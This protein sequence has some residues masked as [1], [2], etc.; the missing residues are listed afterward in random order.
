MVRNAAK[1]SA[2]G[3]VIGAAMLIPG[4]SGSTAAI[5]LGIYDRLLS[6]VG[7]I[8][9]QPKRSLPFLAAAG[10]GAAVGA[11]L[12]SGLVLTLYEGYTWLTMSFFIGAVLGSIPALVK[13]S[14]IK[15]SG[16]L[17]GALF[18]PLGAAAALSVGLIPPAAFSMG[19]LSQMIC[20][21]VIAVAL[22][23]PGISTSQLLL[24]LGMYESFWRAVHEVRVSELFFLAAGG[25]VGTFLTAKAAD[26]MFRRHR[27]E[28]YMLLTGFV[29]ASVREMIP[30]CPFDSSP[31]LC[32]ISFAA[33]FLTVLVVMMRVR[34]EQN[35]A[36]KK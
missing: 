8:F 5:I 18:L 10:C 16:N 3:A 4:V 21:F 29:A 26:C 6:A 23:L 34:P 31:L 15:E 7:S 35:E 14:E 11:G 33:G 1:T 32:G 24:T 30:D 13:A 25:A 2:A 20:G 36:H 27:F 9:S 19:I 22:V 28:S 12:F 17:F